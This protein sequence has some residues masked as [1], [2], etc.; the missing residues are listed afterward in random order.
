MVYNLLIRRILVAL[1]QMWFGL[2]NTGWIMYCVTSSEDSSE[3]RCPG[4]HPPASWGRR[5]LQRTLV[6]CDGI[7]TVR[8]SPH[9]CSQPWTLRFGLFPWLGISDEDLW[10]LDVDPD[11]NPQIH[12]CDTWSRSGCGCGSWSFYFYHWPWRCQPKTNL[13]K[14]CY[15]YYFLKVLLHH[16]SK[17]KSKKKLHNSGFKVLSYY[18]RLI[19]EGSGAASEYGFIPMTNGSRLWFRRPKNYVDPV[20]PD[21]YSDPQHCYGKKTA[22]DSMLILRPFFN[23]VRSFMPKPIRFQVD[24]DPYSDP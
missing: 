1:V 23:R 8:E 13:K 5:T 4:G 16:F 19:I 3:C 18:F 17:V 9:H 15:A 21:P 20:D 6:P 22:V 7:P 12:G 24:P 11:P 10:H 14:K 2:G